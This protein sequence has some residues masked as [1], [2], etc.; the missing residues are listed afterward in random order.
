MGMT[1]ESDI[2]DYL[3]KNKRG[4]SAIDA[5]EMF[6]CHRLGA[7]I[8]DLKCAGYRIEKTMCRKV[9]RYGRFI[10]FARYYLEG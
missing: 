6:G 4:L 8:Y 9:N 5:E 1:Q 3:K 2:L 7:R 10:S